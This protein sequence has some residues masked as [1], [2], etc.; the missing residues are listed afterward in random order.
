MSNE[1]S[2]VMLVVAGFF[3]SLIA[4]GKA[5]HGNMRDNLLAI[6]AGT[7]SAYFLTPVVFELTGIN[8]SAQ[9]MSAMAFLL[10]V[11]GQR[12]VEIV[13]GKVFPEAKDAPVD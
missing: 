3:G 8:A 12:G 9:T 6:S 7:S 5:S 13:I 11:L 10:G 4:V 1:K 2:S